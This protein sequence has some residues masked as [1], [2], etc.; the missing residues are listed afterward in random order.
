MHPLFTCEEET[1]I[2][3][4]ETNISQFSPQLNTHTNKPF[5]RLRTRN[6]Q[7]MKNRKFRGTQSTS[8]KA[9]EC[10]NRSSGT[11]IDWRTPT[12]SK[13][14]R[15]LR[16]SH[17]V[18]P[19]S[20]TT[21]VSPETIYERTEHFAV[22]PSQATQTRNSMNTKHSQNP[23][24]ILLLL[25]LLLLLLLLSLVVID[26]DDPNQRIIRIFLIFS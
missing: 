1:S 16:T 6:T 8:Y 26:G 24:S 21:L 2:N 5:C 19:Y 3:H 23:L 14:L 7:N 9:C 20:S 17:R 18:S 25:S 22:H 10:S 13:Y 4:T 11:T 12:R 15:Q